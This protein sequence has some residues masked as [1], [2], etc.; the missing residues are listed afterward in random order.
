MGLL[1]MK[2]APSSSY[3]T[4]LRCQYFLTEF[5]SQTFSVHFFHWAA[6]TWS[7]RS[8]RIIYNRFQ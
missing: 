1:I 8:N 2:L 7:S 4:H 5:C 3:F 6:D